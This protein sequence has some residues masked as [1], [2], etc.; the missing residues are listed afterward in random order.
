MIL[1]SSNANDFLIPKY[2]NKYLHFE[3]YQI[4]QQIFDCKHTLKVDKFQNIKC[5][6][7]VK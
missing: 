6:Q 1:L 2:T 7:N 5:F 3:F 4:Q